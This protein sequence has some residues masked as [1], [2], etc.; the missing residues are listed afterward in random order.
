MSTL[1]LLTSKLSAR[2]D[3]SP[4]EVAAAVECLASPDVGD[5]DKAAFLT[6]LATKGETPGEVA[7][8]AVEFRGRAVDPGLGAWSERAIDIV[9]TG[10]DHAGAFNI[11]SLVVLVL[12]CAGVPV[13]KHGNRGY[14]SRCG[15][16]DL[17]SALGVDIEAPATRQRAAMEQLGFVFLFAPAYQPA[18]RH[19]G[20]VRKTLAARGQRTI[21]NILG[22]LINPARPAHILL[23]V[24]A[25]P[26]VS[27]LA[28]ALDT[29]GIGAGLAVHG[30]L[31]PHHGVDELT[32]AAVNQVR[33]A[34]RLRNVSGEW[35]AGDFGLPA[36][37]F[38]ELLGGDL[39]ANLAL[40]ESLLAGRGPAG[41][42]D[43]IALNAAVGLWICGRT[44]SVREGINPARDL[45]L[46]GQVRRK[47]EAAKEF[48]R[49]KP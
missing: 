12:A 37:P 13:T 43:T 24:Y 18:F 2:H 7:A 36:S 47:I 35:R 48:F 38:A 49:S 1:E 19:I 39:A 28:G 27:R 46:G 33:G 26:W 23:G 25:S 20:P 42:A 21:F 4:G 3:L 9:G 30:V 45:L 40:T 29:L 8:F 22:P 16:A 10:G 11:S 14:T 34:G 44:P 17:L 5:D 15:S 6:A 31:G 41:L 32:T